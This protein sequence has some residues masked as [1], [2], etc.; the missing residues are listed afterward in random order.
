MTR[1]GLVVA[2]LATGASMAVSSPAAARGGR[3]ST[4]ARRGGIRVGKGKLVSGPG[5]QPWIV[6]RPETDLFRAFT[7]IC[8]HQGC[9]V[10][11]VDR[12]RIFCDC[13]GS[14]FN[15]R[16]GEVVQGP[17]ARPLDRFPVRVVDGEVQVFG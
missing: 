5:G 11:G 10:G 14:R 15:M 4:V 1:R 13:H 6:T 12:R 7:A 3:W 9:T 8:T 16:T 2:A 17:A